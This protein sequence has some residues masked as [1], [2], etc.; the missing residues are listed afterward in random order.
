MENSTGELS[1]KYYANPW[2]T[3]INHSL[4]WT[5]E[6][7]DSKVIFENGLTMTATG[8]DW[9]HTYWINIGFFQPELP[10]DGSKR[11]FEVQL[12]SGETIFKSY[13][14]YLHRTGWNFFAAQI[15][16]SGMYGIPANVKVDNVV[17]KQTAGTAGEIYLDDV[18]MYV[19]N[20]MNRVQTPYITEPELPGKSKKLSGQHSYRGRKSSI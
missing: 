5:T 14:V 3:E 4:K 6:G 9:R 19:C 17:I 18:M 20:A 1:S 13:H 11:S 8:Y 12:T 16:R 15:G 2:Q 7:K 10:N